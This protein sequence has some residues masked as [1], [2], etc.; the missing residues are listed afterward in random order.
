MKAWRVSELD[1]VVATLKPLL[2]TRLQEIQTTA[3][4]L[5]LGFYTSS[6][7]LWLWLD[8][9]PVHPSLLPWTELPLRLKWEKTPLNLFLRA[10]FTGRVLSSM[11]RSQENGRVVHLHFG[12]LEEAGPELEIRLFPHGR[13]VLARS[14]GKQ[15]AWQRPSPLEPATVKEADPFKIRNL[16]ELRQ[17]WLESRSGKSGGRKR[18]GIEDT[19]ARL[20]NELQRKAK[21]LRKVDEE[22]TRKKDLPW[23]QVGNWL[24]EN[25]SLEVPKAWEPFVD[26]RRKL[27]WNIDECFSRARDLEGKTFG[28]E[29]RRDLLLADIA[30]LKEN[31][32]LPTGQW[33]ADA[34]SPRTPPAPLVAAE[35]QGRSLRLSGEVTVIAGK[36]AADNMKLLRKARSWDLWLHLRDFPSSHAILFRNKNTKVTETMLHEAAAWF[37]RSHLG[38]K[39]ADR[40]GE[41]FH[42]MVAECRHVRPI[43][44]DKLGRVTYRDERTLIYKVPAT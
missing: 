13:N 17:Q 1:N 22:L 36:S 9:N 23:R 14:A 40:A 20:E 6:G 27:S 29:K 11:R 44:G 5:V 16:D 3:S 21:A 26:R 19:R 37:V 4:D 33:P 34:L 41:R 2:G 24:K 43:K 18:G 10:H 12:S 31:L 39:F 28:T 30:R 35:A 8:L 15:V 7:L 38:K 25:Q 32:S 42:V